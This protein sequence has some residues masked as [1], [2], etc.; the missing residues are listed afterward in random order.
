MLSVGD[1]LKDG[2]DISINYLDENI[3][4]ID[5]IKTFY[6]RRKDVTTEYLTSLKKINVEMLDLITK[7]SINISVGSKPMLIKI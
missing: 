1:E 2:F 3:S 5:D 7:N 6:I 4:F